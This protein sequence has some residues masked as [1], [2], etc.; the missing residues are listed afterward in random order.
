MNS[1]KLLL[2]LLA[3]CSSLSQLMPASRLWA[4]QARPDIVELINLL[5]PG[6]LRKEN[7]KWVNTWVAD[8]D[9]EGQAPSTIDIPNG[10]AA[11]V[12]SG[13][14]AGGISHE[15]AVYYPEKS[16]AILVHSFDDDRDTYASEIKFYQLRQGRL[17]PIAP[18]LPNVSCRDLASANTIKILYE[19]PRLTAAATDPLVPSYALPR[20]GTTIVASCD[21]NRNRFNIFDTM[22]NDPGL[23]PDT[24]QQILSTMSFPKR[25]EF[26]WNKKQGS[27][28]ARLKKK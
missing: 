27:F 14:G 22:G 12:D 24:R 28:S 26:V 10:F 18:L 21:V 8:S 16:G 5:K 6:S 25:I 23:D 19:N 2:L 13:T 1:A 15:F 20:K 17:E 9:F 4:D 3:G 11:F 7:G